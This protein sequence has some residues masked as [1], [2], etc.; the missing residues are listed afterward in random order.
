M[1]LDAKNFEIALLE[2]KEQ[3][4]ISQETVVESLDLALA[5]AYKKE[6]GKKNQ[7]IQAKFD[8]KTGKTQ[9]FQIKI[10]VDDSMLISKEE[11]EKIKQQTEENRENEEI[12]EI[13]ENPKIIFNEDRHIL[14]EEARKIK[15]DI[16][17]GEEL[18]F[19]LE[20]KSDFGRIAAQTAKQVIVQKIREAERESIF[21]EFKNQEGKIVSGI[22][23][24]IKDNNVFLD[25]GRAVG[26][27]VRDEQIKGERYRLSERV[28]ALLFSVE[29]E[30]FVLRLSRTHPRFVVKLFEI[31]VPE[32]QNGVVE[33]RQVA[34]EPG[35]RSKIA[36]FSKEPS[37]DPVG[38]LVGQRGVR[39]NTVINEL[40]GEKIDIAEWKEDAAQYIAN[41]LSPAKILEV[42][43]F[44]QKK[45]AKAIVA[46][47]QLSLAIG[48][49]GQNV[50]LA[51]KLTGYK[52][53]IQ[54]RAG[55]SVAS[56]TAEGEIA[57][58]GVIK[59]V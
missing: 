12:Q 24:R 9:F 46:E 5:A 37:V 44:E 30:P 16:K 28:K 47:D 48:R 19:P 21:K 58:E 23:Q 13:Q 57:G 17:P 36:V 18:V 20:Q 4:G 8:P 26:I 11:L 53:D 32:I 7:I 45:E 41:A 25:L 35:S 38:S 15:K 31:E 27:L 22:V 34:R 39:V 40:G 33:I 49:G 10:V 2:L 51:A 56:A 43:L 1:E 52:I 6:Y 42:E 3:K 55:K 29:E 14:I 50:Y 54:S 59:T